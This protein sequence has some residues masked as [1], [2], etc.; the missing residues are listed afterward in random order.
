[1]F[2]G[3]DR[4]FQVLVRVPT[5]GEPIC[6]AFLNEGMTATDGSLDA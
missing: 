6:M 2:A 4:S 5:I 3:V 1:M